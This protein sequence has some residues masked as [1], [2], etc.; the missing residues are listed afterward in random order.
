[1]LLRAY[2]RAYRNFGVFTFD[3]IIYYQGTRSAGIGDGQ[4]HQRTRHSRDVTPTHHVDSA[5]QLSTPRRRSSPTDSPVQPNWLAGPAQLT[6]WSSSANS[7]VQLN[8]EH[9]PA[10]LITPPINL[11]IY[12]LYPK[13]VSRSLL[14]LPSIAT[15][16]NYSLPLQPVYCKEVPSL[17]RG[18]PVQLNWPSV[19]NFFLN[20]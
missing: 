9:D 3:R 15:H 13:H 8:Q 2:R 20:L 19:Q 14:V 1:M 12:T 17:Y 5:C 7:L 11:T 10:S 6:R 18:K 16:V 4:H